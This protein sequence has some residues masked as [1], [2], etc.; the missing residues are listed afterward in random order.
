MDN[1]IIKTT[2][3]NILHLFINLSILFAPGLADLKETRVPHVI[4]EFEFQQV[5][6]EFVT[7]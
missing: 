6:Q 1:V 2:Y 3:N 4:D 5:I 7:L